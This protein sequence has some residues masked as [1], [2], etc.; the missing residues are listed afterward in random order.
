MNFLFH[1]KTLDIKINA[2]LLQIQVGEYQNTTF[3]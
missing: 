3:F 1:G 2:F